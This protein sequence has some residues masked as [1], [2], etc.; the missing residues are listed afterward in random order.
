MHRRVALSPLCIIVAL[1][2]SARSSL[3]VLTWHRHAESS[4]SLQQRL[5]HSSLHVPSLTVHRHEGQRNSAQQKAQKASSSSRS[6]QANR[7]VSAQRGATTHARSAVC[8]WVSDLGASG[9]TAAC[10]A[11]ARPLQREADDD[12]AAAAGLAA[13]TVCVAGAAQRD[14]RTRLRS[15][16]D[17]EGTV[18]KN[19]PVLAAPIRFNAPSHSDSA[20]QRCTTVPCPWAT[21]E[22]A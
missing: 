10:V 20:A 16:G 18:G 9:S 17:D 5:T 7:T 14:A 15:I 11:K 19:E 2:S 3:C 6:R 21:R 13:S 8:C 12:A 1:P 22:S 4:D